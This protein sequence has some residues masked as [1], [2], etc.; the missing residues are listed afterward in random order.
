MIVGRYATY[1]PVHG[2]ALVAVR[3]RHLNSLTVHL[4]PYSASSIAVHHYDSVDR[5]DPVMPHRNRDTSP[6]TGRA[7]VACSL[8]RSYPFAA[9]VSVTVP[10]ASEMGAVPKPAWLR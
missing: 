1:D 5:F 7:E 2:R 4:V 10:A 9:T 6:D 8:R 3:P